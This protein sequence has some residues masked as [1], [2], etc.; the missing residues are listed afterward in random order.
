MNEKRAVLLGGDSKSGYN[1]EVGA[2]GLA[3]IG[4]K[5]ARVEIFMS[6]RL[7]LNFDFLTPKRK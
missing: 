7:L 6:P 3:P 1:G 5:K 4:A 2:P